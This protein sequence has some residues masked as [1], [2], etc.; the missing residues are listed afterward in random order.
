MAGSSSGRRRCVHSEHM[1]NALESRNRSV[2]RMNVT[3]DEI[4]AFVS[5]AALGGFTGASASLNRSQ[6]AITRRIH[7]L[8]RS[9]DTALFERTRRRVTLTE[10]GR[11]LLPHAETALAALRE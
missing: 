6:P 2:K 7:K 5:I 11:A 4:E 3:I 9:L 8:E 1:S 10:A